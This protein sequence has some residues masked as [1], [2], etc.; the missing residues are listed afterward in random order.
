MHDGNLQV[1]L[2]AHSHYCHKFLQLF[3]QLSCLLTDIWSAVKRLQNELL[4]GKATIAA[5]QEQLKQKEE[6]ELQRQRDVQASFTPA[7]EGEQYLPETS[8][9]LR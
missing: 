3:G 8:Q 9:A 2:G 4:E 7:E 1:I 6:E 5:L